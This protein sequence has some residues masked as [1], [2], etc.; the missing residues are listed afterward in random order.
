[1][2]SNNFQI[3]IW[4]YRSDTYLE[5]LCKLY[6]TFRYWRTEE[7]EKFPQSTRNLLCRCTANSLLWWYWLYRFREI[8]FVCHTNILISHLLNLQHIFFIRLEFIILCNVI[9]SNVRKKFVRHLYIVF[10]FVLLYIYMYGNI[11]YFHSI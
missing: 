3:A 10:A 9:L 8:R 7:K 4:L 6:G 2:P 1:M 5:E 11:K